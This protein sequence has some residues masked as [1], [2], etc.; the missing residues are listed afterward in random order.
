[1][2]DKTASYKKTFW[3]F[4]GLLAVALLAQ[5]SLTA[6][7]A[8]IQG[9]PPAA[10]DQHIKGPLDTSP[11]AI[12]LSGSDFDGDPLL[13]EIIKQPVHGE[14]KGTPPDL[15]YFATVEDKTKD[16]FTFRASDG[17]YVSAPA[18][19]NIERFVDPEENN[20]APVGHNQVLN[21]S[22]GP[23][24]I[25]LGGSDAEGDPITFETVD[26]PNC[27]ALD[28]IPPNLTY[29]PSGCG[30]ND[31]TD[32]FNFTAKSD[33]NRSV[34]GLARIDIYLNGYMP[35][36][37][38]NAGGDKTVFTG[39]PVELNGTYHD[40]GEMELEYQEWT[41]LDADLMECCEKDKTDQGCS[42]ECTLANRELADAT[43]TLD[44]HGTFKC[45]YSVS[46]LNTDPSSDVIQISTAAT[47]EAPSAKTGSIALLAIFCALVGVGRVRKHARKTG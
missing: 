21:A 34:D 19:I 11:I 45:N 31:S 7:R 24:D 42:E 2:I 39:E 26:S 44:K 28:G 36:P 12:T 41:C 32:G 29:D 25:I 17:N 10:H 40:P 22:A 4:C 35:G 9:T 5:F 33:D 46:T 13:F 15:E 20:R 1:M 38:T 16:S 23:I 27:G 14:L 30:G 43:L 18:T 37:V 6:A 8:Q 47:V 3:G